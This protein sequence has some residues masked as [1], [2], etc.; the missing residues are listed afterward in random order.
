MA[1]HVNRLP[2]WNAKSHFLREIEKKNQNVWYAAVIS[3][4]GLRYNEKLSKFPLKKYYFLRKL[5]KGLRMLVISFSRVLNTENI[6]SVV[7]VTANVQKKKTVID[8]IEWRFFVW[9]SPVNYVKIEFPV[10]T[11]Y[12]VCTRLHPQLCLSLINRC[13]ITQPLQKWST[14]QTVYRK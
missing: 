9:F 7:T 13:S 2:T 8:V 4:Y 11:R 5:T 12:Y 10:K 3:S 14:N 6:N 1:F